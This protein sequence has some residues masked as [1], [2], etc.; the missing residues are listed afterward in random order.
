VRD[1]VEAE[2]DRE[3]ADGFVPKTEDWEA[4]VD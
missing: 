4:D 1:Q 3:T 2:R